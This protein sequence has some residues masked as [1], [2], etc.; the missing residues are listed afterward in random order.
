M[1]SRFDSY[2]DQV[3]SQVRCTHDHPLITAELT[4]HMEDRRDTY[5]RAGFSEEEAEQKAV[6]A[7]GD[8]VEVGKL[9]A[10]AHP[11]IWSFW[12]QLAL[13]LTALL[14]VPAAYAL[15]CLLINGHMP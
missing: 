14:S 4:A 15:L 13:T 12:F 11:S 10:K 6:E 2:C 3:C 1:P 7:M 5:L 9:M 8:P